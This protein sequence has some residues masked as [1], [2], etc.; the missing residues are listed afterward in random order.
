MS[1]EDVGASAA[2]AA[3]M[4]AAWVG[5]ALVIAATAFRRAFEPPFWRAA[6]SAV[7]TLE[8]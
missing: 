8:G 1:A 4:A 3:A 6:E 2:A 7:E 5:F